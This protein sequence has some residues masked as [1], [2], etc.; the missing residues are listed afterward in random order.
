MVY[1]WEQVYNFCQQIS[2]SIGDKLLENFAKLEPSKK[3]DGSLVICPAQ[4]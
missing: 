3:D 1:F 2:R 4:V